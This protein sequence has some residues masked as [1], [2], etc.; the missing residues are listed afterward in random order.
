MFLTIA[1]FTPACDD[2]EQDNR[3]TVTYKKGELKASGEL[4]ADLKICAETTEE[5]AVACVKNILTA[6]A[7]EAESDLSSIDNEEVV[8]LLQEGHSCSSRDGEIDCYCSG[9]CKRSSSDCWCI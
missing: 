4:A 8:G 9:G 6:E 7:D 2:A 3:G 1:L 5:A